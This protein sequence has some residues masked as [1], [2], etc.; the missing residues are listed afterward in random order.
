V[1]DDELNTVLVMNGNVNVNRNEVV[2]RNGN[3]KEVTEIGGNGNR[4]IRLFQHTL[5]QLLTHIHTPIL[6]SDFRVNPIRVWE[7]RS[8]AT[9]FTLVCK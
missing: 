3:G 5:M 8:P 6:N 7:W 9:Y 2:G 4:N 1:K